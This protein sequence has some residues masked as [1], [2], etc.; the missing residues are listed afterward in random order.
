MPS[1]LP[2]RTVD[3]WVATYLARRFPKVEL[4]APTQR[5]TPDFDLAAR[6]GKFFIVEHKAPYDRSGAHW[7][8]ISLEQLWRYC[9][10]PLLSYAV[11]YVLPVPPYPPSAAEPRR[12]TP[13]VADAVMP[14][15]SVTR[16]AGHRWGRVPSWDWFWV[17]A[18]RHLWGWLSALRAPALPSL[19]APSRPV[20]AFPRACPKS[21]GFACDDLGRKSMLR[22]TGVKTL[23]E[24]LT[25]VRACREGLYVVQGRFQDGEADADEVPQPLTSRT[26]KAVF[27][28]GRFRR[29][30]GTQT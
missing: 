14:P 15:A 12:R 17:V 4:W 8:D 28:P 5:S 9:Q 29:Q 18:P 24:Y 2:E 21:R 19:P 11:R 25:D 26:A 23:A 30:P 22:P 6:T 27:V 10:D 16:L 7:I 3:A 20:P 13:L 1:T